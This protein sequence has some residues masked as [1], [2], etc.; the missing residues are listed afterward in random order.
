MAG[1]GAEGTYRFAQSNCLMSRVISF[2]R[3]SAYPQDDGYW[4]KSYFTSS[5]RILYGIHGLIAR[6]YHKLFVF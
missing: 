5:M 3:S 4:K 6:V 1:E 2:T